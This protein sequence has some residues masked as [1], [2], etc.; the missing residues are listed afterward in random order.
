M[1]I[2]GWNASDSASSSRDVAG[3]KLVDLLDR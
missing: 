3:P 2:D 1:Q